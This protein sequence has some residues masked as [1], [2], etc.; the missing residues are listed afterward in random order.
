MWRTCPRVQPDLRRDTRRGGWPGCRPGLGVGGGYRSGSA[1]SRPR[2]TVSPTRSMPRQQ[3]ICTTTWAVCGSRSSPGRGSIEGTESAVP[4]ATAADAGCGIGIASA[5]ASASRWTQRRGGSRTGSVRCAGQRESG[6]PARRPQPHPFACDAPPVPELSAQREV[7]LSL[8]SPA[9]AAVRALPGQRFEP[10]RGSGS[11]PAGAAAATDGP[12]TTAYGP[13]P[14][15]GSAQPS[16]WDPG[17]TTPERPYGHSHAR[18]DHSAARRG[19]TGDEAGQPVH[20]L[21]IAQLDH[22]GRSTARP[23]HRAATAP[24]PTAVAMTP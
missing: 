19:R 18:H 9:G 8:D 13:P 6:R 21:N 3:N 22:Q 11:S 14:P 2:M 15:A 12:P 1:R 16:G 7:R 24:S 4:T 10:C 20:V 5:S 17:A 23:L